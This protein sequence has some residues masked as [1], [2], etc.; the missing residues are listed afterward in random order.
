MPRALCKPCLAARTV[1]LTFAL[2]FA[3]PGAHA[4]DPPDAGAAA[5]AVRLHALFDERWGTR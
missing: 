3:L 5:E 4:A 1:A 2:I